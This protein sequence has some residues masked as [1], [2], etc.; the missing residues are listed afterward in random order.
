GWALLAIL[1]L[2][3]ITALASL[4]APRANPQLP[5]AALGLMEQLRYPI[6]VN[7]P[8]RLPSAPAPLYG[9]HVFA[10]GQRGW[11]V[12]GGGTILATTDGGRS[13]AGQ[14][15]A[16]Q[17]DLYSAA[18]AADGQRGWA[19]GDDGTILAT[20]DGGRSWAAQTSDA[21]AQLWSVTFTDEG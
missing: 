4:Q 21:H 17:K 1:W 6:E 13:W 18:F 16:V 14:T 8:A 20:S 15:S 9:S 5:W 7:A 12:G 10:D 3:V 11:A 19:V 2:V